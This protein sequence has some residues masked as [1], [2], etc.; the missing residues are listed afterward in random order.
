MH[1][2][3]GDLV[4]KKV[5]ADNLEL[6][7]K[8][9]REIWP[10]KTPSQSLAEKTLYPEDDTNVS[11]LIYHRQQLIGIVG[12]YTYDPDEA[13]YDHNE[14]IWLDHFAILPEFRHQ[15]F[16][17]QVMLDTINYCRNL[18]RFKFYRLDTI[19][20]D[21]RPAIFLYDH[22]MELREKY[23]AEDTADA[24]RNYLIYSYSLDGS[25][26]KAWNNQFLALGD[27]A[28]DLIIN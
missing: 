22:I 26:I 17:R 1:S 18:Q 14:S 11:W 20:Y 25:P 13:G 28:N 9:H 5:N 15:G 4:Y 21:G 7:L 24:Q 16:G 3:T 6:F 27:P 10:S 8:T 19:Y 2:Q 12:I 23:T